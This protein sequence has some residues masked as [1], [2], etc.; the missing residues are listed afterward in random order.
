MYRDIPSAAGDKLPAAGAVA[1]QVICLPIY[2][3]LD[4]RDIERIASLITLS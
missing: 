1:Q 4:R 3:T 2:P